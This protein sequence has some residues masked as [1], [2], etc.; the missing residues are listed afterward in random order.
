VFGINRIPTPGTPLGRREFRQLFA[1]AARPRVIGGRGLLTS[2]TQNGVAVSI[3]PRMLHTPRMAAFTMFLMRTRVGSPPVESP[4]GRWQYD[5]DEVALDNDGVLTVKTG[6][7]NSDDDGVA[8]NLVEYQNTGSGIAGYGVDTDDTTTAAITLKPIREGSV[9]IAYRFSR[10]VD[11]PASPPATV[12][13]TW[14]QA[15]NELDVLCTA[16]ALSGGE[17][18]EGLGG[19]QQGAFSRGFEGGSDGIGFT[20][21][22]STGFGLGG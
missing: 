19:F 7:L 3:D 12:V 2:A 18:R 4:P 21:G 14:F 6:G 10:I 9:A 13:E 5:Y 17:Y 22:F 1:A 8:R 20:T 11:D 15:S 16:G